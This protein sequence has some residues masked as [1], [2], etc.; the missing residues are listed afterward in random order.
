ELLEQAL[1]KAQ[2]RRASATKQVER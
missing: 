2:A 1:A